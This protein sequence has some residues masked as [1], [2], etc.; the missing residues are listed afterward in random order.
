MCSV[1]VMKCIVFLV[2]NVWSGYLVILIIRDI[3]L[4]F[5]LSII[6]YAGLFYVLLIAQSVH[7]F[8]CTVFGVAIL[9][10][11]LLPTVISLYTVTP[12][13]TTQVCHRYSLICKI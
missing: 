1:I 3:F 12:L 9:L 10:H 4:I 13:L 2:H 7:F 11:S 8:R 6:F 5:L